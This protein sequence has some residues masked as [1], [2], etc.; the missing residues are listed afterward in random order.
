M[1]SPY[2]KN[3]M[4]EQLRHVGRDEILNTASRF[5]A[6][7]GVD[8]HYPKN[9]GLD[10]W[11]KADLLRR[12]YALEGLD[13]ALIPSTTPPHAGLLVKRGQELLFADPSL[14]HDS[15]LRI[16]DRNGKMHDYDECGALPTVCGRPSIVKMER[17]AESKFRISLHVFNGSEPQRK[18]FH[19]YDIND[20]IDSIP[21]IQSFPKALWGFPRIILKYRAKTR[22]NCLDVAVLSYYDDHIDLRA[23][24]F[25][26]FGGFIDGTTTAEAGFQ[27][28]LS[29]VSRDSGIAPE[30]L[31]SMLFNVK[32]SLNML[33]V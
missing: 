6:R 11:G 22:Q 9:I 17:V 26:S 8:K 24:D 1:L 19:E 10:C 21:S 3:C 15:P 13:S 27:R 16:R 32:R 14:I 23:K 20:T 18:F 2:I 5:L 12:L 4:K 31:L 28:A 33:G 29:D 7:L 30:D 25:G